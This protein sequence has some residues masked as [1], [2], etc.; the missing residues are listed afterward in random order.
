MKILL[1]QLTAN[2]TTPNCPLLTRATD[3]DDDIGCVYNNWAY[4]LFALVGIIIVGIPFVAFICYVHRKVKKKQEA[5]RFARTCSTS[6]ESSSPYP[7]QPLHTDG[8]GHSNYGA[9]DSSM[10]A[11]DHD[12]VRS[13]SHASTASLSDRLSQQQ[14]TTSVDSSRASLLPNV[15]DVSLNYRNTLASKT[16]GSGASQ[17]AKKT[18]GRSS[19][20]SSAAV[21]QGGHYYDSVDVASIVP[22]LP[23][24]TVPKDLKN[25]PPKPQRQQMVTDAN[26]TKNPVYDEVEGSDQVQ[27][28][29]FQPPS[30]G[31]QV[32]D[33]PGEGPESAEQ[34]DILSNPD[35]G[36]QNTHGSP[37]YAVLENHKGDSPTEDVNEEAKSL[38]P[39][40]QRQSLPSDN[41]EQFL[42]S[43][44]LTDMAGE[45]PSSEN[46]DLSVLPPTPPKQNRPLS[47]TASS[48]HR[49]K[50]FDQSNT[51][52]PS[53]SRADFEEFLLAKV[54]EM[55]ATDRNGTF[56]IRDSVSSAGS[57]VLIMYSWKAD[58]NKEL[59]NFK[60]CLTEDGRAYLHK[61]SRKCADLNGLLE[62]LRE[63]KD[64]LPCVL[65]T[66]V[67]L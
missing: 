18:P 8:G 9:M 26:T 21:D 33:A 60:V 29:V 15:D 17:P 54:R 58:S 6:L 11:F 38:L 4:A 27:V 61:S 32:M 46:K 16:H 62:Y 45:S 56:V 49:N 1:Q 57:K 35:S 67:F 52:P 31:V 63:H 55:P 20:R 41:E 66:Q 3:K 25:A 40:E 50:G 19:S 10:D 39:S 47:D 7:Y 51:R 12:C 65:K 5:R 48:V 36:D 64:M 34:H 13:P 42:A 14:D 22:K 2:G 44:P 53:K 30:D 24:P 59:Y 23:N 37:V 28:R 43:D